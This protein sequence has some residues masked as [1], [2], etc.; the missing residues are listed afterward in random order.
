M[1]GEHAMPLDELV[2]FYDSLDLDERLE[3]LEAMLAAASVGMRELR[4]ILDQRLLT[5]SVERDLSRL[6]ST[7]T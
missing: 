2:A 5:F 6:P 7:Q 3:L 1:A 4:L